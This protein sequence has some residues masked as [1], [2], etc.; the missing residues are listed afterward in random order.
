MGEVVKQ[1]TVRNPGF[2]VCLVFSIG[3]FVAGFCVPPMGHIDGSV[4]T[5]GGIAF[6]FATL[7]II[8]VAIKTGVDAKVK[9]G[10]TEVTVGDGVDKK[11]E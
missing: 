11:A 7:E 8:F 6:G 3:L 5:A 4:L 10:K 2:W 9:H 1:K